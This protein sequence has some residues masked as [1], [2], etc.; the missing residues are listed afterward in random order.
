M[1]A[2]NS[3]V[4]GSEGDGSALLGSTVGSCWD[5]PSA[6]AAGQNWQAEKDRVYLVSMEMRRRRRMLGSWCGVV[7]EV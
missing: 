7:G 1:A 3:R 5:R 2:F 6:F 4:R